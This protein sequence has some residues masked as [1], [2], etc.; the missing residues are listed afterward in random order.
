[1]FPTLVRWP[2]LELID[3]NLWILCFDKLPKNEVYFQWND[4]SCNWCNYQVFTLAEKIA[5]NFSVTNFYQ[6]FLFLTSD[7]WWHRAV[8]RCLYELCQVLQHKIWEFYFNWKTGKTAKCYEPLLKW[9]ITSKIPVFCHH[10]TNNFWRRLGSSFVGLVPK[11]KISNSKSS[12]NISNFNTRS[13]F[14]RHV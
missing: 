1:M 11:C 9:M 12:K 4:T 2:R 6:H 7:E 14:W 8:L 10:Q 13:I 3:Q 5:S